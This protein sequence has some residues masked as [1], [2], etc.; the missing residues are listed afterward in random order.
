M[1]DEVETKPDSSDGS[2]VFR[3]NLSGCSG[4]GVLLSDGRFLVHKGAVGRAGTTQSLSSDGRPY[5]AL[6]D[7]LL[8]EGILEVDGD[9]VKLTQDTPFKTPTFATCI[10]SGRRVYGYDKW[11][12]ND[13]QTLRNYLDAQPSSISDG[14]AH[15]GQASPAE[16]EFRQM[17]YEAHV[18][19][20]LAD[21]DRYQEARV[22]TDGFA[23][24]ADEA[25]T[26][27]T[28]LR[29]TGDLAPFIEKMRK[30]AV[31]PG[32]LA[33]N[34]FSGQGVL[35]QLA[36][37]TEEPQRLAGLLA[38]SLT[39]PASDQ[40]A[41]DKLTSM[42]DYVETI[43]VGTHP[44]PGHLPFFLSY[45]WALADWERWPVIWA[46]AARFIEF[47]TGENLPSDPPERY[48]VFV[49]R[50]RELTSDHVEFETTAAWWQN[51]RPV[52]LDEVL[53]DR[54]AFGLDTESATEDDRE[55]NARA[56]VSIA[57]YW[58]KQLAEDVGEAL[59]HSIKVN[60]P[61]A[62]SA[63]PDLWVDWRINEAAENGLSMRVWIN[64]QGVAIA[65]RPG[66]NP[67][68]WMDT[69]A[70]L[71]SSAEHCGKH[72]D[73]RVLGGPSAKI[74]ED[75]GLLGAHW[76]EFVYG[77]WF[78]R[79]E[80]ADVDLAAT[81]VETATQLRPLFDEV[82]ELVPGRPPQPPGSG[83][84]PEP[85]EPPRLEDLAKDL[86]VDRGFLDDIVKLLEDKGQVIFYG[87]PGTGKTYL[88]RELARVLAPDPEQRALV[89]FHPSSSYEDFFE[90][91]RPQADGGDMVYEL[92]AGPLASMAQRAAEAPGRQ[93][94][95]IIDE[96]NRANLPKV[97]GELL[98]LLEYRDESV[99]TLYRP[100]DAFELPRNL[101]FIGTMNTADRSIA[102]VDAAL[103]RRFHFIPF[104]PNRWPFEEL[105]KS[106]LAANHEPEWIGELVA[107]VNYELDR[108]LGGP[109]LLLGQSH[110][111]KQGLDEEAMRRIWKYNI[112]PFIED[113]FF[114]D[115]EQIEYFRF[116][117]VHERYLDLS[118]QAELAEQEAALQRESADP[119]NTTELNP[120]L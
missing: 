16:L 61:K 101:W 95:M 92:T 32:T 116:D 3:L 33:F 22:D 78:N 81:V 31:A 75:V 24:S 39:V 15:L 83:T 26:L 96:I 112:E 115:R 12:N 46:S 98:F 55:I 110:F 85:P 73:C 74:G 21:G 43:R 48:R 113:Q 40:E 45:F 37:L 62:T 35:N 18:A 53:A 52:F 71:L 14:T 36:K 119:E 99:R 9:R 107:Q 42:V 38:E 44:A 109:H 104:F 63:R 1:T 89:Q 28:E 10:L 88:A 84:P 118:G 60:L 8:E 111:M 29:R 5:S 4:T 34:G 23:A 66:V 108:E 72:D 86:L 30:W 70:P 103:R 82:L 77:R 102:L 19:R 100:E 94:V 57:D 76:A 25:L 49:E 27:L 56:L 64:D 105:L 13:G 93:H 117:Q 17:W 67:H 6:R 106:W 90:G 87:P 65:L 114:G 69:V 80:F 59:G 91:Y 47:S 120:N 41:V 97:F 79:E 54:A 20:F 7:S 58:G 51:Q 2:P 11:K 68:G 50:V